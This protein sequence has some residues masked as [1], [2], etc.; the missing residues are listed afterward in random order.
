MKSPIAMGEGVNLHQEVKYLKDL[1]KQFLKVKA[2]RYPN[3]TK[4][5][6]EAYFFGWLK[7]CVTLRNHHEDVSFVSIGSTNTLDSDNTLIIPAELLRVYRDKPLVI[8]NE[9]GELFVQVFESGESQTFGPF[10]TEEKLRALFTNYCHLK[11]QEDHARR[12]HQHEK[13]LIREHCY[14]AFV[15]QENLIKVYTS[16]QKDSTKL[17]WQ[18]QVWLRLKEHLLALPSRYQYDYRLLDFTYAYRVLSAAKEQLGGSDS[19]LT[20]NPFNSA[21]VDESCIYFLPKKLKT[22][23]NS[24]YIP[25]LR[26]SGYQVRV[27]D[28][29]GKYI[30]LGTYKTVAEATAV[31]NKNKRETLRLLVDQYKNKLSDSFLWD[32]EECL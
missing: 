16:L 18:Y 15:V 8:T 10:K 30:S 3:S 13:D 31:Y 20:V 26:G 27:R 17:K 9:K 1:H 5:T 22:L 24:Q 2:K 21:F 4:L 29:F 25:C 14:E 11:F 6:N 19:Y 32:V 28:T 12:K 7:R 23:L